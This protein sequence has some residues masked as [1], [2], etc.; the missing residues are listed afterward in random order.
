MRAVKVDTSI[1]KDESRREGARHTSS[2]DDVYLNKL[3]E[4]S[5][6][7]FWR[8][9]ADF[10]RRYDEAALA[11]A[12][13]VHP[14]AC[15]MTLA[16]TLRSVPTQP[17]TQTDASPPL[18]AGVRLLVSPLTT[19]DLLAGGLFRGDSLLRGGEGVPRAQK[20]VRRRSL[21][22]GVSDSP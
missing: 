9:S 7:S 18:K 3:L 12:V 14:H 22:R 16:C 4:R 5:F 8:L 2:R 15:I 13:V 17:C 19:Q 11:H 6:S 10:R 1:T 21:R 20:R